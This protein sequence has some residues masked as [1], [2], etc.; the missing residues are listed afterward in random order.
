MKENV[1]IK[2]VQTQIKKLNVSFRK[3]FIYCMALAG[4]NK[5]QN[6]KETKNP[7]KPLL[8]L[9]TEL[10]YLCT[11]HRKNN[12]CQTFSH[13]HW[14]HTMQQINNFR[15]KKKLILIVWREFRQDL[16]LLTTKAWNVSCRKKR[17]DYWPVRCHLAPHTHTSTYINTCTELSGPSPALTWDLNLFTR[18][19]LM[20]T[21]WRE[22]ALIRP[23]H[24]K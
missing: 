7:Q 13:W 17:V 24:M 3:L 18:P 1:F 14:K 21:T 8:T 22:H 19:D 12:T 10:S 5:K 6:N 9:K 15:V 4:I 20:L 11:E 16:S 23:F 2:F